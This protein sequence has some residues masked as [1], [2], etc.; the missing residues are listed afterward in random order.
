MDDYQVDP[1]FRND[2]QLLFE[3]ALTR[4]RL[5]RLTLHPL[6]IDA[7]QAQFAMG[8]HFRWIPSRMTA[9]CAELGMRVHQDGGKIW[10]EGTAA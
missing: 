2:H 4:G 7:C 3:L 5:R 8:E 1:A 10:I 9:L 6:L